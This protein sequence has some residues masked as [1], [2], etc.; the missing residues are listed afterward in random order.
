[1]NPYEEIYCYEEDESR[2]IEVFH[3][4]RASAKGYT[5]TNKHLN[6]KVIVKERRRNLSNE[7]QI[8]GDVEG[9]RFTITDLE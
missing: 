1:M 7:L 4:A 6:K 3:I 5:L 9:K 2:L 8:T